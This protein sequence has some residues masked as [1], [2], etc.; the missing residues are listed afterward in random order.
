VEPLDDYEVRSDR[1]S[2][3]GR[4]DIFLFSYYDK[5]FT[6]DLELKAAPSYQKREYTKQALSNST[7]SVATS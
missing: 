1:E 6:A 7:P 4:G 2:E 3:N 5:N